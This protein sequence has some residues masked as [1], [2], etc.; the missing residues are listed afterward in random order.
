MKITKKFSLVSKSGMTVEVQIERTK[1]IQDDI[2]Y[3]DG[4]NINLGKKTVDSIYFKIFINGKYQTSSYT[5]PHVITEFGY[6]SDYKNLVSKGAY[7]RLGDI[8]LSE[9]NYNKI[10][11]TIAEMDAELGTTEEFAEV[12]AQEDAKVAKKEAT[13]KA[14]EEHYKELIASGMCPKCGTWC[15]GD[16]RG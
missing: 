3:A 15:Y 7:A 4:W 1:K 13:E 8:Y 6:G 12:K 9:V 5:E 10:I 2:S 14:A 11:A 16:C